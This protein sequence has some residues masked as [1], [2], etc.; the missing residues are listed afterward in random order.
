MFGQ[1]PVNQNTGSVLRKTIQQEKDECRT[2]A[3]YTEAGHHIPLETMLQAT[4]GISSVY[5]RVHKGGFID[6]C[7]DARTRLRHSRN[8]PS[9]MLEPFPTQNIRDSARALRIE[10]VAIPSTALPQFVHHA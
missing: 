4:I 7:G 9:P 8:C 5:L 3:L 10:S 1:M 6:R 2:G